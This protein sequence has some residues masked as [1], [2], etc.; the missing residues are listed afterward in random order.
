MVQRIDPAPKNYKVRLKQFEFLQKEMTARLLEEKSKRDEVKI[1]MA[2]QTQK[3]VR[4]I[5]ERS[6][7]RVPTPPRPPAKRVLKEDWPWPFKQKEDT[8]DVDFT[9]HA[10]MC[11]AEVN[12]LLGRPADDIPYKPVFHGLAGA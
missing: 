7:R 11:H 3:A 10:L 1:Q 12:R 4:E 8:A 2:M 5:I 6:N 9:A